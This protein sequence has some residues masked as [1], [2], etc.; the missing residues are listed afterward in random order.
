M[1]K[2]ILT[3]LLAAAAAAAL[4]A[5]C[6]NQAAGNSQPA[7]Q[8]TEQESAEPV[9]VSEEPQVEVTTI[10]AST[11]GYPSPYMIVGDDNELSGYDIEVLQAVFDRLPQYELEIILA[12]SD[13][14]LTG[15]TSGLYDIAVNN[16]SYNE[17]RAE[18][19]YY[20]YPYDKTV[21]Y[22]IQRPDDEPLTS[23]QDAA[24]RGYRYEA[25]PGTNYA[26]AIERWNEEHPDSQ[27]QVE[28]SGSSG[29]LSVGYERLVDGEID[30]KFSDA[31]TYNQMQAEYGF[32]LVA[33][34]I[35]DEEVHNVISNSDC[36]YFLF[37]KTEEGA[38]L[39][40]DVNEVLKQ[41]AEEGV[42]AELG[43]KYFGQDQ[44]P[45]AEDY[46]TTLN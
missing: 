14:V 23:F 5:G 21:M 31:A 43:E 7:E 1:K 27:I 30:F 26:T 2:R 36:T 10:H 44:T 19:Y 37:P 29:I 39:R 17:E 4:L 35:P 24:D 33:Y 25:A 11:K 15:L 20:S 13:S 16:F 32:D 46:E 12:D 3:L 41:L 28:Y 18:S 8:E 38:A 6:S 42:L 34:V 9:E 40:A 22:F 45:S